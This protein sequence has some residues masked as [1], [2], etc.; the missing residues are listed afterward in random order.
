MNSLTSLIQAIFHFKTVCNFDRRKVPIIYIYLKK[1]VFFNIRQVECR[2]CAQPNA[3]VASWISAPRRKH[4]RASSFQIHT[5]VLNVRALHLYI[6]NTHKRAHTW[7]ANFSNLSFHQHTHTHTHTQIMCAPTKHAHFSL[8]LSLACS[9]L[10]VQVYAC[11]VINMCIYMFV[12]TM[13]ERT[14]LCFRSLSFASSHTFSFS[15]SFFRSF[16]SISFFV[17]F[18]F[19][20]LY[21][22]A[23]VCIF[24]FF[25]NIF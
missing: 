25:L 20:F 16:K 11:N 24:L 13:P 14:S 9:L 7:N 23:Y 17:C 4:A 2:L 12:R 3:S 10:V 19:H 5:E 1:G 18:S 15:F 6:K 21:V 22:C 8:A